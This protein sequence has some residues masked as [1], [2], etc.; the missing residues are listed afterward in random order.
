MQ[1][2]QHFRDGEITVLSVKV[3]NGKNGILV[4]NAQMVIG[5]GVEF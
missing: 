5:G 3:E 4:Q 1:V 2:D